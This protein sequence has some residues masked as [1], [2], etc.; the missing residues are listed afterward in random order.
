MGGKGKAARSSGRCAIR[1]RSAEAGRVRSDMPASAALANDPEHHLFRALEAWVEKGRPPD[2][3]VAARY[4]DDQPK[5]GV[6]DRTCPR[7]LRSRTILSIIYSGRWKHGWKREGRPIIWSLRDTS[8]ISRSRACQI[9][10]ARV[11]CARE[12]S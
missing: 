12:R 4:V 3:L 8:T 2:H 7:R 6:S 11:G 5:Q 9:G 10:H 1:R